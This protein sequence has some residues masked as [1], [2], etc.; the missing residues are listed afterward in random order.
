[1][2]QWEARGIVWAH[3]ILTFGMCVLACLGGLASFAADV[4][5][6]PL[7]I[8]V[9]DAF[10]GVR[11]ARPVVVTHAGD[12]SN[13]LFVGSQ[14]GVIHV[15]PND[16]ATERTSVFLDIRSKVA[17]KEIENEKGFLGLAFHPQYATNGRFF[18]DYT[19]QENEKLTSVI[20][21][22][23]VSRINANQAVPQ[24]ERVILRIEQP[25]WN[26]NGG[27]LTFGPDGYLYIA[28]G[29]GGRQS[30]PSGNGQNLSTLL[31]SILRIDVDRSDD[32]KRYAIPDDNP[33]VSR[34][35]ARSE[36]WAYG[37]RNVWRMA[38]DR[39]TGQLW[40][41]DNG[42]DLW[43]EIDL[44][45]RG[46]NYGWRLREGAH[47]FG[48]RGSGQRGDLIDPIWEYHHRVG[49]SIIG[50]CVYRGRRLPELVGAYLY[51][52]YVT[53]DIWALR[54]DAARKVVTENRPVFSNR[55]PLM[56]FGED[57]GGEVYV[58]TMFSG[59][60]IYGFIRRR[61]SKRPD[62][63]Q[64]GVTATGS[65]VVTGLPRRWSGSVNRLCV[66]GIQQA[67]IA[68]RACWT[69]EKASIGEQSPTFWDAG[70]F[71]VRQA[72]R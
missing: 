67:S 51:G 40:A 13:R 6:R 49:K 5:T 52:D 32:G 43:E 2:V 25:Y 16:A 39:K 61:V 15:F 17:Y 48:S 72:G 60:V 65:Q 9:T 70:Q 18:V 55:L 64:Y 36:I 57:E 3:R 7:P 1:M 22:Y 58:T 29:D 33:F 28:L 35:N 46:G 11:I 44:V 20:A 69:S 30:D 54:Y 38:F 8:G 24:S 63:D 27:T 62:F 71:R 68:G 12:A 21:E 59:G 34:T 23:R 47:R 10:P 41:G 53:G 56:T 42:E 14:F 37:F 50:G 26:H 45:T 66:G 19:A 31:G 4:D